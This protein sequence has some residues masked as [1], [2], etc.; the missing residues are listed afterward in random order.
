MMQHN[1]HRTA[2][3]EN[4][5]IRCADATCNTVIYGS[6]LDLP[7]Q[8]GGRLFCPGCKKLLVMVK[9]PDCKAPMVKGLGKVSRKPHWRCSKFPQC[10][11]IGWI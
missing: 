6:G 10:K 5:T 11:R 4:G 8:P 7:V 9:C 2:Y 1:A 3:V